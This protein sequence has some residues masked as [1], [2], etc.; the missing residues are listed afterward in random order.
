MK[1]SSIISEA[2]FYSQLSSNHQACNQ[3]LEIGIGDDGAILSE[4]PAKLCIVKDI[5]VEGTHFKLE[6]STFAQI[7]RKTLVSNLSD[8]VAMGA[9]P[10]FWLVGLALPKEHHHYITEYNEISKLLSEEFGVTL[11][12][13]DVSKSKSLMVSIT[14][15]G[16]I[17]Q[18]SF[19]R[20]NCQIGHDLYLLGEPGVSQYG[21]DLLGSHLDI[22]D[23]FKETTRLHLDPVFDLK[24][25]SNLFNLDFPLGAM[26]LSDGLAETCYAMS[27]SSNVKLVLEESLFRYSK[28]MLG[29]LDIQQKLEYFLYS[30]EE[31]FPLISL[32]STLSIPTRLKED[33]SFYKIGTVQEGKGVE[34]LSQTG[35][36][37]KLERNGYS[38]L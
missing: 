6:W 36:I 3:E 11:I 37:Y 10:M 2:Q 38:H 4:I 17:S 24:R 31:Y 34:I 7:L 13:G 22:P 9:S 19:L 27:E 29:D 25:L 33:P 1:E 35:K 30:G 18:H 23:R 32:P 8:L 26:D 21:L 14:A 16:K 15:I 20:S 28:Y 5:A 12:G